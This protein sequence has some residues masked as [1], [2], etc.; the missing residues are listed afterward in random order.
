MRRSF[1]KTEKVALYLAADGKS[2]MSGE[3]L[4]E[5]WHADHKVPFSK[6]GVTDV[7]NAQALTATENLKKG[8]SMS[9][10]EELRD[11]QKECLEKYT[12]SPKTN[13]VIAAVPA[14]GKSRIG[15]EIAKL[16]LRNPDHLVI[17]VCPTR[18]VMKQWERTAH[19]HGFELQRD[20]CLPIGKGYRGLTMTYQA[21]SH[22]AATNLRILISRKPTMVILDEGHHMGEKAKWGVDCEHAFGLAAKRIFLSGT[23]WRTK[24][25]KIPFL[26]TGPDGCYEIDFPYDYLRALKEKVVRPVVFETF[27]GGVDGFDY[28]SMEEVSYHSTQE[29][30]KEEADRWLGGILDHETFAMDFLRKANDQLATVRRR[31]PRAAGLVIC[32]HKWHARKIGRWLE[33]ITGQSP[34]IV[35]SESDDDVRSAS[36]DGFAKSDK[37][38]IVAVRMV[39]EGVDIPRLMVLVY[40]TNWKTDLFFRQAIGRIVRKLKAISGQPP[41][42]DNEAY[43]FIPAHSALMNFAAQILEF[44]KQAIELEPEDPERTNAGGSGG[45][46][47]GFMPTDSTEAGYG[48]SIL[49]GEH[50]QVQPSVMFQTAAESLEL[51]RTQAAR[52]YEV[53][54]KTES[55]SDSVTQI[56]A[57]YHATGDTLADRKEKKGRLANKLAYR[58][59]LKRGLSREE[60]GFQLNSEWY[61]RT[62][63]QQKDMSE[64]QLD[65]K[66]KCLTAELRNSL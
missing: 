4:S 32:K 36:I 52:L 11:W 39:S 48:G 43:C 38:W 49:H 15:V 50:Y 66:I 58:V 60:A 25:D 5:N 28:R 26:E 63:V 9:E 44:Q 65:F 62:G 6:G 27:H 40:A 18:H 8:S 34:D 35:V 24:G 55:F 61:K 51:T 17:V 33:K 59:G 47:S 45:G 42:K 37:P 41:P 3:P 21:C 64:E 14:A 56:P 31:I 53:F 10:V 1:S 46:I 29:L 7:A 13:F 12:Q 20:F 54:K 23:P 2:E 19:S 22:G 57:S 30:K 16:F